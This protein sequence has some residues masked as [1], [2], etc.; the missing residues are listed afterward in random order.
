MIKVSIKL[1]KR[2]RLKNGK[3]P[4]KYKIARKDGAIYIPTGY[5]L[6]EEE[7]DAENERVKSLADRR[8]IN[9]KLGS[10]FTGFHDKNGKDIYEGDIL[11][12][13][14]V[15]CEVLWREYL[16]GFYLKEDFAIIPGTTPLG[17]MLDGY[18][19]EIIGSIYDDKPDK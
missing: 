7:W 10:Q 11:R 3:Y 19:Y 6:K 8:I 14:P 1:D 13:G 2:R 9:I 16:G 5:E 15:I 4:L 18:E 17:L 12:L